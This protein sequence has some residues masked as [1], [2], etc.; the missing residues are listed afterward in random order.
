M[1]ACRPAH[2]TA[3]VIARCSDLRVW[4]PRSRDILQHDKH[5]RGKRHASNVA[6]AL[7][8]TAPAAGRGADAGPDSKRKRES[9]AKGKGAAW[10]KKQRRESDPLAAARPSMRCWAVQRWQQSCVLP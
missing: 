1:H 6:A 9:A 5:L 2:A 10:A 4:N 7:G 3:L 8:E